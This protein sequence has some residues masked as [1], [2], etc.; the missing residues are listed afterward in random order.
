MRLEIVPASDADYRIVSD[1]ARFYIDDIAE[2]A[3]RSFPTDGQVGCDDVFA[4][5]W[6]RAA[7]TRPWPHAWR[8]FPFLVRLDG[9]PAGFALV[10]RVS[11]AP[12]TFDMGE[13][14]VARQHRRRG[15]GRRVAVALFD[16]FVGDWEVRQMLANT[17]AQHF[18]RR[19]IADYT[20][21]A[22]TERREAFAAYGDREFIVQRFQTG[23]AEPDV[24]LAAPAGMTT[25]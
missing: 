4:G 22:F 7:A 20:A 10:K 11:D 1:L 17:P 15:V 16:T 21:G 25:I 3:G 19:I 6:G 2:H 18:W 23:T 24:A 12:A 9:S 13:F 8:G 5:Y 14:F